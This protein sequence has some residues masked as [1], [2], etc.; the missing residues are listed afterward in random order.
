MYTDQA[1]RQ[2]SPTDGR[3]ISL[4]MFCIWM[5]Y[6]YVL[7]EWNHTSMKWI[8]LLSQQFHYQNLLL[9]VDTPICSV[10]FQYLRLNNAEWCGDKWKMNWKGHGKKCYDL[11]WGSILGSIFLGAVVESHKNVFYSQ[12]AAQHLDLYVQNMKQDLCPL[13]YFVGWYFLT[14]YKDLK[15]C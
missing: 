6:E 12:S 3:T 9:T 10:T 13:N 1:A 15:R 2:T 5:F 14:F 7:F 4:Y 11:I 8:C